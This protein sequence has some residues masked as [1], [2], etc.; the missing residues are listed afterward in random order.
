MDEIDKFDP[1]EYNII[2]KIKET[3]YRINYLVENKKSSKRYI[4]KVNLIKSQLETDSQKHFISNEIR[5]LIKLHHTTIDKYIAFSFSDFNNEKNLTILANFMEFKSLSSI[6]EQ[7]KQGKCPEKYNNTKRQII[8]IGICFGMM[9]I[10]KNHILHGNLQAD[11]I[12][13]DDN[14]QPII[15]NYGLTQIFDPY[16]TINASNYA[17]LIYIAPEKL[18]NNQY[19]EKSDV[20]SFGMMMYEI[21]FGCKCFSKITIKKNF[22]E[23]TFKSKIINGLR[24]KFIKSTKKGL[25]QMMLVSQYIR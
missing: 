23:K 12:Y 6:I 4:A 13:I 22:D 10:H 3:K 25:Q 17:N 24:P 5:N 1:Q 16:N 7:E 15:S 14:F 19:D 21:I 2:N 9:Y 11:N 18:K 20:Y 8:L